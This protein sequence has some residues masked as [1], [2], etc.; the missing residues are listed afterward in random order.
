MAEASYQGNG[1]TLRRLFG[2]EPQ[3]VV[4]SFDRRDSLM[5]ASL[6]LKGRKIERGQ[7]APE[8]W[9]Q[10]AIE[11]YSEVGELRY[12][13]NATANAASRAHLYVGRWDVESSEPVE[14]VDPMVRAIF[15]QFGGG[16]GGRA[17]LIKRLFVQLFVPGDGYIIGV[18][19]GFLDDDDKMPPELV[20]M[21]DL[22]WHV[23]ASTEVTIAQGR[24]TI[25]RGDSVVK[26]PVEQAVVVRAWR[27]NPFRW[28]QADSPV[29]S[30]LPV[31]REIVGLTKHVS[32]AIDSRLAGA[33]MLLIG[34]SFSVLAGQ[35]PDAD[36][37]AQADPLMAAL[38]DAMLTAIKDRDAASAVVPIVL[39]GPDDAIDK[40]QHLTF[41][42]PFDAQSK[43]LRDEAI[44]RLALGLDSPPEVLL[45]LGGS[46]HWNAWIIQDDTVRT[47]ID[48]ALSLICEALTTD[49]L[50]PM[51]EDNG[52]VNPEQYAVWFDSSVLTQRADRSAE[53]VRLFELGQVTG[54]ALRRETGFEES[55]A[56]EEIDPAIALALRIVESTPAVLADPGLPAVVAQVR[57]VMQGDISVDVLAPAPEPEP[58]A[59]EMPA[60]D[61][62]EEPAAE[63]MVAGAAYRYEGIDFSPPQG[64]R[65]EAQR[66]LDWRR[67][68]G[69]GGTEVGIARARDIANGSNLS[70][71]T[72]RRMLAFFTRHERNKQAEGFR[73]GEDGF[74]SNGRI[75]WAL[76]GGDPGFAWARKVVNQMNSRDEAAT[77]QAPPDA[78][79]GGLPDAYR[80][81]LE[82]DVPEGRACGNC[83]FY[84]AAVVSPDGEMA[85]CHWWADYVRGDHY[86]D[87][88]QGDEATD[89]D[90]DGTD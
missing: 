89:G 41:A 69:R 73:P 3:P 30:N 65:T 15:D 54:E 56:P 24:L 29:R 75:A 44:R 18:P 10:E 12:V 4:R 50:W 60:D 35:S 28:W 47:H 84:D 86:C 64:A 21:T 1:G 49:Y 52:V 70:P 16:S 23:M 59:E 9:Q 14:V 17:E 7:I 22:R 48:P 81:A 58:A 37:D 62:P 87:A 38:M 68:H 77:Y 34:E 55:D 46:N 19:P 88:W 32:A 33:G 78:P 76:W 57:A 61:M 71:D 40:V 39:Q 6:R 20:R 45:G 67:E 66:G 63:E 31:L 5:A 42:T 74:P 25:D 83:V 90:D 2:F 80:P 85:W 43:E 26:L 27:P 79:G 82:D 51:L 53:A 36:D 72:M 8:A 13:A 11:L